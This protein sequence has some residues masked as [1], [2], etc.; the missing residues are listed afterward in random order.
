MGLKHFLESI[1]PQFEKGGKLR[2]LHALPVHVGGNRDGVGGI[3]VF[4]RRKVI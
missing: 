3:G 2:R 1:E 4:Q